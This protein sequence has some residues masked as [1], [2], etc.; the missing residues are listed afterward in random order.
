M[1]EAGSG[2]AALTVVGELE[3]EGKRWPR[4]CRRGEARQGGAGVAGQPSPSPR[5][6]GRGR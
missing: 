2:E 6:E 4:L 5:G 3:G 1:V